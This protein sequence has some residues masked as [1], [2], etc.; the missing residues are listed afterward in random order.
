MTYIAA[1][2]GF[3]IVYIVVYKASKALGF[4]N[5][6]TIVVDST[7]DSIRSRKFKVPVVDLLFGNA[8]SFVYGLI[9]IFIM[10]GAV[11]LVL[12]AIFI[13]QQVANV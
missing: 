2:I 4:T 3:V 5:S 11:A 7:R 8:R 13:S 10:M 1:I 9:V 6:T 12:L